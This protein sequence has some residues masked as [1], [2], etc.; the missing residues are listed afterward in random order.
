MS[1]HAAEL[2]TLLVDNIYGQLTSRVFSALLRL[3]RLPFSSIKQHTDLQSRQL[4]HA[5]AVLIQQHLVLH[6]TRPDDDVTFYEADWEAAYSLIRC[7]KVR[8]LVD[9]TVGPGGGEVV[10]N[11]LL[12]GHTRIADLLNSYLAVSTTSQK[13]GSHEE[14]AT[15]SQREKKELP[16][17]TNSLDRPRGSQKLTAEMKDLRINL[18]SLLDAGLVT[19]VR[20]EHFRSSADNYMEAEK[21]VKS[22]LFPMGLKGNKDQARLGDRVRSKLREWRDDVPERLSTNGTAHK[23]KLPANN[24][25][26]TGVESDQ[27]SNLESSH[28][29]ASDDEDEKELKTPLDEDL[30]V[31]VNQEKCQVAWRNKRLV[32]L[33]ERKVGRT[34]SLVYEE[35][36]RRLSEQLPR[37]HDDLARPLGE[38]DEPVEGPSISSFELFKTLDPEIDLSSSVGTAPEIEIDKKNA[39]HATKSRK[40]RRLNGNEAIAVGEVG[41]DEDEE[42]DEGGDIPE[43]D[44][45]SEDEDPDG[46]YD[47]TVVIRKARIRDINTHLELLAEDSHHFVQH[48]VYTNHDRWTVNFPALVNH[49]KNLVIDNIISSR[50][51]Q[52]AARVIGIL[53]DKGKLDERQIAN[54]ALAP[55]KHIRVLLAEMHEVGYL[56]L[57]EVPRDNTRAPGRTFFLW[58]F[59]LD[60]CTRVILEDLYKCLARLLQRCGSERDGIKGLLEKSERTDVVGME[61]KYLS[62]QEHQELKRWRDTE[63]RLLVQVERLDDLVAILR[64]F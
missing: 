57:Q 1:Q 33:V 42:S 43:V 26:P 59:D 16:K 29:P 11:L 58:Y 6:F 12:L 35:L 45:D 63:E 37:C 24:A 34:T 20:L 5:L 40:R 53:R 56:E 7:G 14:V 23:V 18:R 10:S 17:G 27:K 8:N 51:D 64:D 19:S 44:P 21:L 22:Q 41:S 30:V 46:D 36:L 28:F 49:L 3:G 32:Q 52:T 50:W 31:R 60:R 54:A 55:Q 39:D 25:N 2:C 62:Q 38:D 61:D 48:T 4:Q 9:E 47:E 13:K 15:N